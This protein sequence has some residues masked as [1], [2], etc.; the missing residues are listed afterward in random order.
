MKLPLLDYT[1]A[2]FKNTDFDN[3]LLIAV[4]HILDSNYSMFEYLFDMG[5]KPQNTF[6]LG[7]CYSTNKETIAKFR[8]KG[9]SVSEGSLKFDSHLPYDSQFELIVKDFLKH[10]QEKV[11][12]N[13]YEKILLVD[14]GGY[15]VNFGNSFFKSFTNIVA[16]EQTSSGYNKL[17]NERIHFPVINV[18]RSNA[19]LVYESPFIADLIVKKLS[20]KLKELQLNPKS[21]L[22]IGAGSIGKELF[23]LL[24]NKFETHIYDVQQHISDFGKTELANIISDF[25]LVIG[26]SGEEITKD[27]IYS[28]LKKGAILVSASSSD[29][30]FNAVNLR[31]F[32]PKIKDC[33]KEIFV[34]DI[35][36]LNC[37]FPLNFD[38]NKNSASPEKIQLTRALMF[39][40][41]CLAMEKEYQKDFIELE[42]KY[43]KLIVEKFNKIERAPKN[44]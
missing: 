41:M 33:H 30:E 16:I 24:K 20:S 34:N 36:L 32:A 31:K 3:V 18:A 15:L 38:G 27:K 8:K 44:K 2:L 37:G 19:K 13:D 9:V 29:R 14:D 40:A 12:F 11:N 39:S 28:K 26:A 6:L 10:I 43:Q 21:C 22:I 17:K 42:P 5:L 23:N 1:S 4:Q 35:W 25:D 7:K